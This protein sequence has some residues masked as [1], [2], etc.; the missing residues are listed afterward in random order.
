M[1]LAQRELLCDL[2]YN[3]LQNAR[4]ATPAGGTVAVE[5]QEEADRVT[6]TVRDTGCG[7]PAGD[8]PHVT[9]PFYMVDK[10]RARDQGGSGMGLAL[11]ARIAELH[12]TRLELESRPGAG[13]RV[14]L[15]LQKSKEDGHETA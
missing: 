13:T 14:H 7:I 10:S 9:E 5:V 4:R 12:G 11:C 6:L 8:L 1:G 15:T 2:L 3:L